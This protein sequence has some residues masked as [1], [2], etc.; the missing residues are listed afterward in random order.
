MERLSIVISSQDRARELARCLQSL[1]PEL[2]EIHEIIVVDDGSADDTAVVAAVAGCTVVRLGTRSGICVARNAGAARAAGELLAFIDDDTVVDPGWAAGLRRAFAQGPAL[3]GGE[4][5]VP[6]PRS[7]A[8]WYRRN[9]THHDMTAKSGFL[10]FV[11]GANF[12]IRAEVFHSLGGFDEVLPAS[13][14]MDLSFRAQLAGHQ[15]S[16]APEAGLTHWCRSSVRGMLRQRAHHVHGDRV[17]SH[18]YREFPFQR[19]KMWRRNPPRVLLVQTAGQLMTGLRGERR[20]LAYPSLSAAAVMAEQLG[21]LKADLELVSGRRPRPAAIRARDEQQRRTAK[22]LP[23][24]PSV[25]LIGDDRLLAAVLRIT[26]EATGD[27]SVAPGGLAREALARWD[28]PAPPYANL[29]RRARSS[30]WLTP[31]DLASERLARE[32]P[33]T[34][35][36]AFCVLHAHQASLLRRPRFGLLALD[37]AGTGLARRFPDLPVVAIGDYPPVAN[38][39][40]YRVTRRALVRDRIRVLRELR[41][42]MR[43]HAP[44]ATP[45][46]VPVSGGR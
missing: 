45:S 7:L 46:P 19:T 41:R 14:D 1:A 39:V 11:C 32:R 42:A 9:P 21:V 16:F 17:V 15:V 24:G 18:K 13:E 12:A 20:R 34:W 31:S 2:S 38:R 29:A 4:I 22:E 25:L 36:E 6:P 35:G 30:G 10:P 40:V 3:V 28:E 8:E 27:L 5:R 23:D 26:F 37:D 43:D 33:R 44:A